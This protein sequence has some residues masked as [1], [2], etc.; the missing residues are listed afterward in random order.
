MIGT[1]ANELASAETEKLNRKITP[2]RPEHV[3]EA[4]NSLGFGSF[5]PKVTEQYEKSK[6][7]TIRK[8]VRKLFFSFLTIHHIV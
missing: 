1:E 4:L 7:E 8:K 6:N 2:I 3:M 5:V